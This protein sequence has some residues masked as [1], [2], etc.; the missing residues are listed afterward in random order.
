MRGAKDAGSV[1]AP[2]AVAGLALACCAGL[3]AL[4]GVFAAVSLTAVI[5]VVGGLLAILG[6]TFA[7]V[8]VRAR[9][10]GACQRPNERSS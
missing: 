3:P 5:G 2:V 7:F 6:L 9:R 10:R 4:A 8:L 1:L